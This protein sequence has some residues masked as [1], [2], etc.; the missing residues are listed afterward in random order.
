MILK[1]LT[2]V[3]KKSNCKLYQSFND[4]IVLIFYSKP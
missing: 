3:L 2:F 4:P 1:N